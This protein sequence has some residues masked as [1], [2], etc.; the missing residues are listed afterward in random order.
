M[1]PEERKRALMS[2][3]GKINKE[4]DF[5]S[6][7]EEGEEVVPTWMDIESVGFAR[8]AGGGLP[9]G[10][11][12]EVAGLP[13]GGKSVLC[14]WIAA[15]IQKSGGTVALVDME[16][17]F[18]SRYARNV[19]LDT[20]GLVF[21]SP[22]IGETALD[23]VNELI[24]SGAIDLIVIDSIDALVSQKEFD[25]D[26]GKD[27]M[28]LRARLVSKWARRAIQLMART[29]TTILA[30]NQ[31]RDTMSMYGP[32]T[33]TSGGKAIEFYSSI[34]IECRKK[35]DIKSGQEKV[36]IRI[37]L[38]NTKN[39]CSTPYRTYETEMMFKGGFNMA[40]EMIDAALE[41]GV[42]TMRGTSYYFGDER[43]AIGREAAITAVK[44]NAE[45]R[46]KIYDA[47]MAFIKEVNAPQNGD[48]PAQAKKGNATKKK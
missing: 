27:S 44:E 22:E 12:I 40:M 13:S 4:D 43:I 36:G 26:L 10:K 33:V 5:A 39:K 24:E 34:R 16:K 21:L 23:A 46:K 18:D 32:K 28:A 45:L 30:I 7:L 2:A 35:E 29:G 8:M 15:S 25:E 37:A 11:L 14:S 31:L 20:K 17:S 41:D 9:K 6:I 19:G 48:A 47:E 3:L 38:K 1:T 42:V